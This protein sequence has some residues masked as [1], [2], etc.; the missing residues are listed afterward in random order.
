MMKPEKERRRE[1]WR[2]ERGR[3]RR[4]SAF[5]K[6]RGE[7]GVVRFENRMFDIAKKVLL[8]S[9]FDEWAI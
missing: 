5:S 4:R 6:G 8:L 3:W 1:R 7:D 9:L 2:G